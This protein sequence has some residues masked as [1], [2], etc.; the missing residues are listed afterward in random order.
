[1]DAHL[2][3]LQAA[4]AATLQVVLLIAGATRAVALA[5]HARFGAERIG[6]SD[7]FEPSRRLCAALIEVASAGKEV[8]VS[9]T[10]GIEAELAA[11]GGPPAGPGFQERLQTMAARKPV[12]S[13]AEVLWRRSTLPAV[14]YE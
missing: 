10:S 14:V 1:M 9:D 2:G 7:W 4:S 12:R 6:A 5:L 11:H 13:E 8:L 3:A